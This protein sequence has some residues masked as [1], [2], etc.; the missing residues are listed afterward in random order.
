MSIILILAST[1]GVEISYEFEEIGLSD[2]YVDIQNT[3]I[4][5][6]VKD[7]HDKTFSTFW[8]LAHKVNDFQVYASSCL[9]KAEELQVD[10][11]DNREKCYS[12][13]C[14]DAYVVQR[15]HDTSVYLRR[16]N[17]DDTYKLK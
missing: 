17:T 9:L 2:F 11:Y 7:L 5:I 10:V 16:T 14:F 13:E 1:L 8:Q 4:D 12:S 3:D 6:D 15:E